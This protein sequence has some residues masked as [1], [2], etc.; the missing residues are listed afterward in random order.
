MLFTVNDDIGD[1]FNVN[2]VK[3]DILTPREGLNLGN[4]FMNEYERYKNYRP[5][6]L[7]ASSQKESDLWEIMELSFAI[8]DLN[9]K[10]DIEPNDMEC[11]ALFNEYTNELD[12]RV[13]DYSKKYDALELCYDL[14]NSYSWFK[15]VWPW[16]GVNNV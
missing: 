13:R 1:Y 6:E 11:F 12:K 16:E 5:R 9:L 8:N 4:L 3:N 2:M 15:G 7:K 14:G 10:L